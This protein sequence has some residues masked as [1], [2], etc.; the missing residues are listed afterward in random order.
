MIAHQTRVKNSVTGK[1]G[2]TCPDLMGCCGPDELAVVYDGEEG[3]LG[4]A[5]AELEILGPEDA[6]PDFDQ[7]GGG[8]GANCCVF[9]TAGPDGLCCERF[10]EL[11]WSLFLNNDM[12]AQRKP[13]KPYPGC[14]DQKE[15]V[16]V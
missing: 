10:S 7:C 13:T 16:D 15:S 3:F 9:L 14:M 5:E 11:R 2:T 6:R 4:T 1:T 12:T 8:K